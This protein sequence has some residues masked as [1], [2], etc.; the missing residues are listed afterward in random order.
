MA[1][2]GLSIYCISVVRDSSMGL[3]SAFVAYFASCFVGLVLYVGS[4]IGFEEL[5]GSVTASPLAKLVHEHLN[6][7]LARALSVFVGAPFFCA[8][9]LLAYLNQRARVLYSHASGE[10][11]PG[12]EGELLLTALAHEQVSITLLLTSYFLL[13]TSYRQDAHHGS[14]PPD[15]PP[16]CASDPGLAR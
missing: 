5:M 15:G 13:L 14:D 12:K 8:Y 1:I 10:R 9:L 3:S 6:G 7:D 16:A 11:L 2:L 4:A